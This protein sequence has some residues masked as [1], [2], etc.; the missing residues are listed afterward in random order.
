LKPQLLLHRVFQQLQIGYSSLDSQLDTGADKTT[1]QEGDSKM[2]HANI[3]LFTSI[4]PPADAEATSYLHD[5]LN[6]W[7]KAGFDAVA[8]NG[9]ADTEALRRLDLPIE[10]AVTATDG[11]PR[12]GAIMSAIRARG[13]RFAGIINSDCRIINYPNVAANLQMGLERAA[14]LAWRIDLGPDLKPTTMRGGFDAYFFDTEVMPRDDCGFSIGDP[15]W[16]YWFPLACEMN[17]ARVET[18]GV[19]LLTHKAHPANWSEQSSIRGTYRF[20]AAFQAWH[21]AGALPK[22]LLAQIPAALWLGRTPSAYQLQCIFGTT[23]PAWLHDGRPQTIPIMRPEAAEIERV[24][25]FCGRAMLKASCEAELA[26]IRNSTSWRMTAPLRTAVTAARHLT[27]VLKARR[28]GRATTGG[29]P[30]RG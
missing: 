29:A 15:W 28:K 21:R 3:C 25:R 16:D 20:W 19:P 14:V 10:F 7:R 11:K 13:C 26:E 8:V 2:P 18:L 9:R 30:V 22:S 27:S 5:C 12:I 23:I 17:G 1:I 24:L 4:R 6:S